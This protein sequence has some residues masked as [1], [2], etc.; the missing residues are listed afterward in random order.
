VA[1]LVEAL[2]YKPEGLWFDAEDTGTLRLSTTICGGPGICTPEGGR[3][4]A[5]GLPG[6]YSYDVGCSS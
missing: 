5:E 6:A 4:D 2:C 3:R 1:Q